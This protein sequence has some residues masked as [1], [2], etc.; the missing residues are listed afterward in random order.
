M[1]TLNSILLLLAILFLNIKGFTQENVKLINVNTKITTNGK[2]LKSKSRRP[3]DIFSRT[4]KG[5]ELP[6]TLTMLKA[7]SMGNWLPVDS[8]N[9]YHAIYKANGNLDT[10]YI[11]IGSSQDTTTRMNRVYD[12]EE[13][14]IEDILEEYTGNG[15]WQYTVKYGTYPDEHGNDT[16]IADFAWGYTSK[17]WFMYYGERHDIS[18]NND[19]S[20]SEDVVMEWDYIQAQWYFTG[21]TTYDYTPTAPGLEI[22]ETHYMYDGSQWL[23]YEKVIITLNDAFVL[24]EIAAQLWDDNLQMWINTIKITDFEWYVFY[25]E[26]NIFEWDEEDGG[27]NDLNISQIDKDFE[28]LYENFYLTDFHVRSK[29]ES[30]KVLE[31][32][33]QQSQWNNFEMFSYTFDQYGGYTG[34]KQR[35]ANNAWQDY[36][37]YELAMDPKNN[38]DEYAEYENQSND[39]IQTGGAD[40]NITYN[41]DNITNAVLLDYEEDMQQYIN[42]QEESYFDFTT[43][44]SSINAAFEINVSGLTCMIN[45]TSS[46]DYTALLWNFGDGNV[47][48]TTA[49]YFEYTYQEDGYYDICLLIYD[50]STNTYDDT[51][52]T[53]LVGTDPNACSAGFSYTLNSLQANFTDESQGNITDWYWQFGDGNVSM[54]QNPSHTYQQDGYYTVGLTIFDD[55]S[56]CIDTYQEV[57]MIGNPGNDCEADFD[58]FVD[59][60]TRIAYFN[61]LSQGQTIDHYFWNFGDGFNTSTE[62]PVHQYAMQGYYPV[63]LSIWSNDGNCYNTTCKSVFIEG[64]ATCNADFIHSVDPQTN[65]VSFSDNSTGNPVSWQWDFGDGG[66]ANNSNP[67]YTYSDTGM[68]LAHLHIVTE[69]GCTSDYFDVINVNSSHTGIK[70]MFGY[71]PGDDNGGKGHPVD[72]KSATYGEPARVTWDFGDGKSDSTTLFPTH[73]Y[74]SAGIYHVCFKIEDPLTGQSDTYCKDVRVGDEA[75]EDVTNHD[76]MV[77]VFPNPASDDFTIKITLPQSSKVKTNIFNLFG[78][79]VMEIEN[80]NLR[81]GSNYIDC[82]LGSLPKGIYLVKVF[83]KDRYIVKKLVIR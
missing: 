75:I 17:A 60:D 58:Y 49:N 35:Y 24:Q 27:F 13:N 48:D 10:V 66:G 71:I 39:W 70:A 46:G 69:S 45:N 51:C 57:V 12:Q 68:Y 55:N 6:Q 42:Q 73:N 52:T 4:P 77:D 16:L 50:E 59:M 9:T 25:G 78:E 64:Q 81:K 3:I 15:I 29:V 80:E 61:N 63:C 41:G 34:Y 31:W 2:H 53:V 20:I 38:V 22:T 7:D 32:D 76:F 19:G 56:T 23:P 1:K 67:V 8:L 37:K 18:Y 65:T 5:V 54:Q 26:P 44:V 21:K 30:C 83:F 79:K 43:F 11:M 28:L 72:Y 36:E 82:E 33:N 47:S 74:D 62:N 14:P 40:F